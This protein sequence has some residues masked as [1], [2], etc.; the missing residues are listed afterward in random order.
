MGFAPLQM[1]ARRDKVRLS[2]AATWLRK[3]VGRTAV[4]CPCCD[5][6]I[7]PEKRL[8]SKHLAAGLL[9][10][11]GYQTANK[12]RW[13]HLE[14][15]FHSLDIADLPLAARGELAALRHWNLLLVGRGERSGCYS[16]TDNGM[17]AIKYDTAV[18]SY[19]I[20]FRGRFVGLGGRDTTLRA[21]VGDVLYRR[22][23]RRNYAE[24][25][26]QGFK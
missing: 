7:K 16:V 23:L 9:V 11:Y 20:R 5:Q 24:R 12:L 13:V 1:S 19:Q 18:K 3:Y 8:L 25:N 17:A 2:E 21:I 4:V 14:R 15:A 6:V 22:L 10:L 26:P